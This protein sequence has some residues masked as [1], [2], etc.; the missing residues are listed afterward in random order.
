MKCTFLS[1]L[2]LSLSLSLTLSLMAELGLLVCMFTVVY[3]SSDTKQ[4][5]NRQPVYQRDLLRVR[6]LSTQIK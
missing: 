3:C 5:V 4:A 6:A 1:L 2:S